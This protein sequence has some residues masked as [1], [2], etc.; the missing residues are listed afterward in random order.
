MSRHTTRHTSRPH[1]LTPRR[2]RFAVPGLLAAAVLL[3]G[4][5]VIGIPLE[6]AQA[7]ERGFSTPHSGY[8]HDTAAASQGSE[9]RGRASARPRHDPPAPTTTT[10]D[11][12][13]TDMVVPDLAEP[14]TE[15]V[16]E[17]DL[18]PVAEPEPLP[19]PAEPVTEP[20]TEPVIDPVTEPVV[21]PVILAPVTAVRSEVTGAD[22]VDA[23]QPSSEPLDTVLDAVVPATGQASNALVVGFPTAISIAPDSQ[24][25]DSELDVRDSA[26]IA[27]LTAATTLGAEAILAH[28]AAN[29]STLGLSGTPAVTTGGNSVQAFYRGNDSVV[30]TIDSAVQGSEYSLVGTFSL[31][32]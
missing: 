30:V 4:I 1:G 10:P 6:S 18:E 16:P 25:R 14:I 17:P 31:P 26:L 29:L 28:F 22:V 24:I 19:E 20:V 23:V 2:D 12:L 3:S 21:E 5:A 11:P 13:S 8:A 27:R 9:C 32:E 7:S 15:P